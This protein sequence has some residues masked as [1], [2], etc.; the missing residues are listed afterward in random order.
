MDIVHQI[1]PLRERRERWRTDGHSLALVPT[2]GNLHAGHLHLV[3]SA[4]ELAD[5]V[6]VS[7]FI[8]P[9]QFSPGEDLDSYPRTLDADRRLLDDLGVDLLFVPDEA[10]LYPAGRAATTRVS[11][12]GLSEELCGAL[13]PGHFEGV[14]TVVAKLF[15]LFTPEVSVFGKKDYQQLM[16]IRRLVDDL[17][18]PVDVVG[19]DTVREPDGLAMSSRNCYLNTGER[20]RAAEIYRVL[21]SIA[22]SLKKGMTDYAVL[23]Q[24]G[25]SK[26]SAA[27]FHP[28]YVV[29][30]RRDDLGSP[31]P[32]DRELIVLTAARMGKARLIDNV[33]ITR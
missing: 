3:E 26:L 6:A 2:M 28:D 19:V 16:V 15:N 24:R 12:P 1:E 8:N 20:R 22:E 17:N 13:R 18:M 11:V 33:E 32:D 10:E 29:V 23:E 5:R 27:G 4:F 9:L 14:A 31:G 21:Q 30:R 7:I 25:V